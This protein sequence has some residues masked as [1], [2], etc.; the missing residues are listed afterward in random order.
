MVHGFMAADKGQVA[1]CPLSG[2][3]I[4]KR[5]YFQESILLS[6]FK[7]LF[8]DLIV[9]WLIPSVSYLTNFPKTMREA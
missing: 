5:S 3:I 2:K 1:I 6:I 4:N 8:S 9:L 7:K